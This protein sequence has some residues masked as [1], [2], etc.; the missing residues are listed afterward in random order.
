TSPNTSTTQNNSLV[1][2]ACASATD[3]WA[4]GDATNGSAEQTLAEHWNGTS[5][6]IVTSPNTLSPTPSILNG[7]TCVSASNCWAIGYSFNGANYQTLIERWDGTS[8]AVVT[9]ANASATEN[10]VLNGVTCVSASNCW[11]VGYAV[12]QNETGFTYQTLVE[13]W[14]GTSWAI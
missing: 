9:S 2:V 5:W 8:W 3:C 4:A 6:A 12:S 10:N 14:D 7:V 13:R 11:A 1:G